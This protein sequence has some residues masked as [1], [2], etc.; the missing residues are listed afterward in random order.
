MVGVELQ[1]FLIPD[2]STAALNSTRVFKTSG[3]W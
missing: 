1:T 2:S 3:K